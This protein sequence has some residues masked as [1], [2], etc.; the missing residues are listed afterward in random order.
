MRLLRE[1]GAVGGLLLDVFES[2]VTAVADFAG[3][4]EGRFKR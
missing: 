3:G 4:G 2:L 1:G